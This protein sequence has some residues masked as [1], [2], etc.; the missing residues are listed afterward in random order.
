MDSSSESEFRYDG[1]EV[2]GGGSGGMFL[3]GLLVGLVIMA[4][5][6]VLVF[7]YSP[8]TAI[9]G[10]PDAKLWHITNNYTVTYDATTKKYT[11]TVASPIKTAEPVATAE[12]LSV[13]WKDN[14]LSSGSNSGWGKSMYRAEGMCGQ[15]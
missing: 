7:M 11:R 4:V 15:C 1:G 12:N 3:I 2:E 8:D 10:M 14:M 9:W 5:V 13:I 6:L